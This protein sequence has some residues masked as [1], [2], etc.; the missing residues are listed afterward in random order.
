MKL[1]KVSPKVLDDEK[2]EEFLEERKK[3]LLG[4]IQ[5]TQVIKTTN[6]EHITEDSFNLLRLL[7]RGYYGKVFLAEKKNDNRLFAIKAIKKLDIIK[8]NFIDNLK[9][10]KKIMI[11]NDNPFVVNLE[12]CYSN[13]SM[14]FFAMKFK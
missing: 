6:N 8:R 7:G 14:I 3:K 9:N 1:P 11:E 5:S 4:D 2:F 12:Y 10:E 13:Q